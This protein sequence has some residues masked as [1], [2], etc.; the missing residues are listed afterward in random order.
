MRCD[1]GDEQEGFLLPTFDVKIDFCR[2]MGKLRGS[3]HSN[4]AAISKTTMAYAHFS[5]WLDYGAL[6]TRVVLV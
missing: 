1:Q 6:C 2:V 5:F 4:P 3:D